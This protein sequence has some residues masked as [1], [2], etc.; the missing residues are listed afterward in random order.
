MLYEL[1]LVNISRDLSGHSSSFQDSIGHYLIAAYLRKHDF[2]A[3]VFSGRVEACKEVIRNEVENHK[4]PI[5]GFY[6]AADN[7][8]IVSHA[9]AWVKKM[10]PRVITVVG[11][12]QVMALDYEFFEATGNDFAIMGEGEIPVKRLL[13]CLIDNSFDIEKIPS[14]IRRDDKERSLIVNQTLDAV[15]E[16]LDTIPYPS[17]EDSVSKKFRDGTTVGIITGRGCPYKCTFCYEGA[18]AKNVRFRSIPNVMEE[19]D[20]IYKHN[21]RLRYI[22][23]YDDTFT[24]KKERVLEFCN[25]I[26]KRGI[27]WFCEGHVSFVLKNPDV[28]QEMVNSGL[29]CIQF[30]IES[31]SN[32][33]LKAY[34]KNTTFDMIA[35]TIKICKKTGIH[36]ITG[37]FI[38]GG[39]LETRH[40]IEESKRLV[41]ELIYSAKGII[42]LYVVY[43][44]PYPNT[45]IVN[46]PGKFNM[47]INKHFQEYNLNTMRSPVVETEELSTKEIYELKREFESYV[48]SLYSEATLLSTKEDVLQ[49]LFQDGKRIHLNPTWERHYLSHSHIVNFIE[50]LSD[51]EQTFHPEYYIIR[52]FEDIILEGEDLFTEVGSFRGIEKDILV[53]ASG[54][55]NSKEMARM[56][57]VSIEKIEEVYYKLN[58]RCLVYVSEF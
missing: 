54:V 3:Y 23:I 7:I 52:T 36:G 37:N 43:F 31:G 10:F 48:E 17:M 20:Y 32:D 6:V 19:I 45:E 27:K 51:R 44:A 12:P 47:K 8:R 33:V 18:N 58:D 28:L 9:I 55:Y 2:K 21:K 30:G 22:N 38:I 39:A 50:H 29:T 35:D 4:V 25:E 53:N 57:G 49:G 40:S 11:G 24:I 13:E 34:N 14:L 1:L 26:S 5:I 16:D 41:K 42:E 46:N 56:F 15:I